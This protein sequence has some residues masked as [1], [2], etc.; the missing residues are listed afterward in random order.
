[1]EKTE[2][3]HEVKEEEKTPIEE[4]K[5][6]EKKIPKIQTKE[7]INK[8][9]EFEVFLDML[10][11]ESVHHWSQIAK[12]LGV[13]QGTISEWK[14]IPQAQKAIRDGIES[15]LDGMTKAG[16]D[17]WRMWESKLKMLGVAPIEKA[18]VTSAGQALKISMTSYKPQE[19]GK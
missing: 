18:D 19:D 4:V 12:T 16:K 6:P 9:A 8:K 17:E 14:K 2:E 3:G 15:A 11:G 10:R 5:K 13:D 7:R 1:M